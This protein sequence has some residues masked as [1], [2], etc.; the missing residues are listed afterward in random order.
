MDGSSLVCNT[1]CTLSFLGETN[2]ETKPQVDL[3][4]ADMISEYLLLPTDTP[5]NHAENLAIRSLDLEADNL[6]WCYETL[7]E[8]QSLHSSDIR[9]GQVQELMEE[10]KISSA[11]LAKFLSA[12]ESALQDWLSDCMPSAPAI[13]AGRSAQQWYQDCQH[14][15]MDFDDGAVTEA[16][17]QPGMCSKDSDAASL[18]LAIDGRSPNERVIGALSGPS[19]H[20]STLVMCVICRS[21]GTTGYTSSTAR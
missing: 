18:L 3:E 16:P 9:P 4:I 7:D 13:N 19:W 8:T 6:L 10:L 20:H 15:A 1:D 14:M 5:E 12:D 17:S 21:I 11:R 2:M